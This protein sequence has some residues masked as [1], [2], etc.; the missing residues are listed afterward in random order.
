M[1]Q[2]TLPSDG[3]CCWAGMG[4]YQISTP[5][6]ENILEISYLGEPPHGDSY[7][8]AKINGLPFPGYVWGCLF[9]STENSRYIFCSWMSKLLERKTIAIDCVE[10]KY[11]VLPD[12]IHAFNVKWPKIMGC[13]GERANMFYEFT[14]KEQWLSF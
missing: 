10:H 3:S 5:N 11:F 12:Y 1:E 2:I 7:H 14:G 13:D 6:Q 4:D 9:A 8:T